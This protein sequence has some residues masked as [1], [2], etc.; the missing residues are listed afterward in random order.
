MKLPRDVSAD[1]LIRVLE[2]LGYRQ[3]RQKG[4]HVRLQYAREPKHSLSVPLHD[5]LKVGL[6]QAI[7]SQVSQNT[8]R[9]IDSLIE[10]LR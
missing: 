5:H 8:S 2:S 7:L 3:V 9:T 1:R 6:L 10:L 4:S